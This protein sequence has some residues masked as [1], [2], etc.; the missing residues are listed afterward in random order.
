M[1]CST[2]ADKWPKAARSD[3]HGTVFVGAS[4]HARLVVRGDGFREA[5]HNV[6][7]AKEW[8][9][10]W[11]ESPARSAARPI[12]VNHFR[13][14]VADSVRGGKI[15]VSRLSQSC[16]YTAKPHLI[17]C[18][19]RERVHAKSGRTSWLGRAMSEGQSANR[20]L[21][22]AQLHLPASVQQELVPEGL[23]NRKCELAQLASR[24][25]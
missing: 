10:H 6:K 1:T 23:L 24:R 9:T 5:P 3:M 2:W 20:I 7:R 21:N 17:M 4:R 25:C 19:G 11:I 8:P 15:S 22:L 18:I 14:S 12:C 16:S 13:P